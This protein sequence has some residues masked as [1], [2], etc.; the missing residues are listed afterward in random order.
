MPAA[1]YKI[2]VVVDPRRAQQGVAATEKGLGRLEGQADRLRRRLAAAFGVIGA[3]VGLTASIRLLADFSQTMSTV[4][5]VSAATGDEFE[6]LSEKAQDLG[7]TT[8]FSASQASEGM[9]ALARAGFEAG[10][11]LVS[12]NDTL[13]LAQA[14]ALDLGT[15]AEITAGTLGGFRLEADQAGRVADVLATASNSALT[16]VFELGDALKFAGPVAAGLS[17]TLEETTAAVS[18]LADANLRGSLGG[19]GLRRVLSELESPSKKTTE[20]LGKL[21]VSADQVA[22]SQVGLAQ[23]L[24][25]LKQAGIDTGLALE[26]FGDRG[27]PAFEVLSNN[28]PKIE[29]LTEKFRESEGAARAIADVMDDNLQG[30]FLALR[31]AVEGLILSTGDQGLTGE[32][33]TLV[34]FFTDVFRVLSGANEEF[35]TSETAVRAFVGALDAGAVILGSFLIVKTVGLAVNAFT[36]A[37]SA[38]TVA[39]SGMAAATGIATKAT[40]SFSAALKAIPLVGIVSGLTALGAIVLELAGGYR[41]LIDAFRDT[42]D[43]AEFTA[44][45]IKAL[46][47][48]TES[49][50][51]AQQRLSDA[52]ENDAPIVKRLALFELLGEREQEI[53]DLRDRIARANVFDTGDDVRALEQ[54]LGNLLQSAARLRQGIADIDA[55]SRGIDIIPAETIEGLTEQRRVLEDVI[56]Q[57]ERYLEQLEIQRDAGQFVDPQGVAL[58]EKAI[59]SGRQEIER[60]KTAL[61]DVNTE[62]DRTKFGLEDT[63]LAGSELSDSSKEIIANIDRERDLLQK[64]NRE[65]RIQT[66]L[67]RIQ[68]DIEGKLDPTEKKL[69]ETRLRLL[70]TEEDRAEILERLRGPQEEFNALQAAADDLL[71]SGAISGAEYAQ[72]VDDLKRKLGEP[73]T[74]DVPVVETQETPDTTESDTF[75]DVLFRQAQ[76]LQDIGG[77]L[78]TY[79]RS[80]AALI[81]LQVQGKVTSQEFA[82]AERDLLIAFLETQETAE[83]GL[84]RAFLKI[85]K[86][87]EDVA[88][89]VEGT[90]VG[91]FEGLKTTLSDFFATGE[92]SFEGFLDTVR[93]GLA[94]LLAQ[95]LLLKAVE[96]LSGIPGLGDLFSG[97]PGRQGGGHVEEGRPY[98]VG[99]AGRE[100]FVPDVSGQIVPHGQIAP[101]AGSAVAASPPVMVQ[102][103]QVPVTIVNVTSM[104]DV[105]AAL[106]TSE[107]G[108]A[109]VNQI[110]RNRQAIR[111]TLQ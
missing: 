105:F 84:G 106:G 45:S 19:T 6:L 52:E 27:G 87:L 82:D 89:T 73:V 80:L 11:V 90:V 108:Q 58:A 41:G 22:V 74:V 102:A 64:S 98:V 66:E 34:D 88:T 93:K 36:A 91:A 69:I 1:T 85:Q 15:A 49:L 57:Q 59:A 100:L 20:L 3:G 104:D 18:A 7:R 25:V 94:D 78:E 83:A 26:I 111:R 46:R 55:Q 8:R 2:D 50:R 9:V 96:G 63:S 77:P 95:L 101:A 43:E 28:I 76:I 48:E 81:G 10:E 92:I 39:T 68:A 38:G 32:L 35:K 53:A 12:V 110:S 71:K 103:P 44:E 16:T 86:D 17:V 67:I 61:E 109:I 14:G 75:N 37:V 60:L 31:S 51:L 13:L 5:A 107:G 79:N 4:R 72:V 42:S 56:D 99:E 54:R 23:A 24:T 40:F 33:R 47:E 29:E 97:L 70:Q 65:R 62:L 30:S 21:G